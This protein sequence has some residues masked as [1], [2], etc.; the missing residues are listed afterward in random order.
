[1]EAIKHIYASNPGKAYSSGLGFQ[2]KVGVSL[3]S[4]VVKCNTGWINSRSG[5][6]IARM[7]WCKIAKYNWKT[8]SVCVFKGVSNLVSTR[9]KG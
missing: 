8:P 3:D 9:Q 6:G 5:L 1:M 4:I 7:F 2:R